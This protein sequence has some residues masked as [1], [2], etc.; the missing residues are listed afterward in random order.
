MK[1]KIMK[2]GISKDGNGKLVFSQEEQDEIKRINNVYQEKMAW[3]KI[4]QFDN[5][6]KDKENYNE[7][8][9]LLN[10]RKGYEL[11]LEEFATGSTHQTG[12]IKSVPDG[13]GGCSVM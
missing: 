1:M 11:L 7:F 12:P 10:D 4:E 9:A 6:F 8:I 13:V 5:Y 2:G 3:Y